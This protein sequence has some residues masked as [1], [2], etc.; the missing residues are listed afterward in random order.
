[1]TFFVGRLRNTIVIKGIGC[2]PIAIVTKNLYMGRL[3]I[4][5]VKKA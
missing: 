4:A 2:F 5:I 3:R 1:M